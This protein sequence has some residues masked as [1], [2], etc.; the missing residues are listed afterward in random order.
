MQ[1][2]KYSDIIGVLTIE[3]MAE[4]RFVTITETPSSDELT[5]PLT[6]LPGVKLPATAE[7]AARAVYIITWP[8]DRREPPIINW[9]HDAYALRQGFD[10][11]ASTPITGKTIYITYP[12]YQDGVTIPSGNQALAFGGGVYTLPS[13]AYVDSSNIRV[14]GAAVTAANTADDGA[15]EA[16]KPKYSASNVIGYVE[17]YNTTTKELTVRTR[18]P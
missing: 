6:D 12:G 13:G 5:G 7:E 8:V 10:Q 15:G 14:R 1:I 11:A 18:V 4:G 3:D 17:R 16:G 2:N 9:P